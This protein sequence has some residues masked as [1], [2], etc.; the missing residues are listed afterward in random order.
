MLKHLVKATVEAQKSGL[1]LNMNIHE[2]FDYAKDGPLLDPAYPTAPRSAPP[3]VPK[4]AR[5]L[6]KPDVS[7]LRDD[8]IEDTVTRRTDSWKDSSSFHRH[9]SVNRL[10]IRESQNYPS[11]KADHK[12]RAS[13]GFEESSS[14]KRETT[15][16]AINLLPSGI[17][18][19]SGSLRI[20]SGKSRIV[21][22]VDYGTTYTGMVNQ[23]GCSC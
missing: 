17:S 18:R 14:S 7:P 5:L 10:A 12:H 16:L 3:P 20:T 22:A 2:E 11:Q 4:P 19:E 21:L 8:E 23:L 6:S 13:F 15:S 1:I 9:D